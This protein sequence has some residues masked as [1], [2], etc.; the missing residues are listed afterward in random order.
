M[1]ICNDVIAEVEKQNLPV[2]FVK[3]KEARDI[4]ASFLQVHVHSAV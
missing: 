1:T 3:N 4:A 2:S